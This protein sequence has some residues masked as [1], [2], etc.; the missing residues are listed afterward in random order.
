MTT[1]GRR[2]ARGAGLLMAL[3]AAPA[4]AQDEPALAPAPAVEEVPHATGG[5][6]SHAPLNP[7]SAARTGLYAQPYL[8]PRAG[9][10]PMLG[11]EYGSAIEFAQDGPS[12]YLLDAEMLR[13]QLALRKDL[14][15]RAFL[16]LATDVNRVSHGF[17]DG[18]FDWYHGLI[19]FGMPE[20]DRRPSNDFAFLVRRRGE[21]VVVHAPTGVFLGDVR[22]GGGWRHNE[23]VQS[24]LSV[25][26]PTNTGPAGYRRGGVSANA[27][28][29]GRA[30][31]GE[32]MAYEGTLGVGHTPRS[33]PL[34]ALQHTRFLA[35]SS[36]VRL[37]LWRNHSALAYA[38]FHSPYYRDTGFPDMDQP[39]WTL[40]FGWHLRTPAGREWTAVLTEDIGY[41]DPGVDLVLRIGVQ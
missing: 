28:L 8:E 30:P 23:F 39:E 22:V 27:M 3:A 12:V 14:S 25:T 41:S 16:L 34:E 9:W 38:F 40:S 31:L 15:P 35:V 20:R 10:Q 1:R 6:P 32:R 19:G 37:G 18:F 5:V 29:A 26:L 7:V 36:G 2:L 4:A 13:V 17:A 21:E 24:L 33:G 11:V